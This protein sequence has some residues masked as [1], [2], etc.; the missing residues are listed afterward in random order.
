MPRICNNPP[1]TPSSLTV[2]SELASRGLAGG[3]DGRGARGRRVTRPR[4]ASYTRAFYPP[5]HKPRSHLTTSSDPI[6]KGVVATLGATFLFASQD[7]ITKH[8]AQTVSIA[9]IVFIRFL[10]FSLFAVAY[11][12]RSGGV[13]MALITHCG[14]LQWLRGLLIVIEIAMFALALRHLGVA[15]THML[16][17]CFPL[18]VTALSVPLLGEAVGWRRW[19]AV[20]V[21]FC[22]TVMILD[23]GSGVFRPE[24]LIALSAA[25]MFALYNVVT[26]KTGRQDR[27]ETSL[28]YFG[29]VGLIASALA[30]PFFWSALDRGEVGWLAVLTLTGIGGH[31]L[32]I[33]ALQWA[34]A[35]VLQPFNYF[36]LVWAIGVGFVVY[37]EILST[38]E[39]FGAA[40]VVSSGLFIAFR[41]RKLYR[42]RT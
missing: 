14:V 33:K 25:L 29:V 6:L 39:L 38:R 8:L 21:G 37:G 11:A 27:F 12:S 20:G 26:R 35:A 3:D 9:Q 24:T 34:P 19:A 17:A 30:A 15:E 2:G 13:R 16:F 22:G 31:L 28:L 18:M 41:E 23:P 4:A 42:R 32:L 10:F 7:A 5:R 36:L 1:A 40:I